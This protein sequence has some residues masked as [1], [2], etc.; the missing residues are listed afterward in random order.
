MKI[1]LIRLTAGLFLILFLSLINGHLAAPSYALGEQSEIDLKSAEAE[2]ELDGYL[3][4]RFL[5]ALNG[6][7]ILGGSVSV[8]S[9]GDFTTDSTGK[10]LFTI[11][12]DDG[13]YPVEFKETG[14]ITTK[15]N[16]EIA[17]GTMFANWFSISPAL[18]LGSIRIVLDWGKKPRDLDLH[19]YKMG[20]YHISYRDKRSSSRQ[21]F[22]K[23]S[24][25]SA[26][27][28]RDDTNGYGPETITIDNFDKTGTYQIYVHD[29]FNRSNE[30]SKG[31]SNSHAVLKLYGGNSELLN[32]FQVPL[33]QK[34]NYWSVFEIGRGKL[35]THNIVHTYTPPLN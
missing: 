26:R 1:Y 8:G 24:N 10:I 17:A 16:I 18:D 28:D 33:N 23:P 32:T 6:K 14:F 12:E 3:T 21:D 19:V 11:P 30:K 25:E 5:N 2:A 27:L 29:Y 7:A 34:G 20:D 35:I 22:Y 31:L 9:F 4:L 13:L 15:F